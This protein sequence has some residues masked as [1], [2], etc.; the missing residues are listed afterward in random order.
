[1]RRLLEGN[2]ALVTGSNRG[3]GKAIVEA[4]ARHG[5]N[6]WACARKPDESFSAWTQSLA[7]EANV[8]IETAYFDLSD[9]TQIREGIKPVLAAKPPVDILVNNAGTIHTGLFQMTSVE[10]MKEVFETNFFSQ[11]VLTQYLLKGM[12]RQKKG[13]IVHVSSSAAI[14][15]NEGRSAYAASKA[16]LLAT[17][18]VM[19]KELSAFN[20][21]VNA[22]APGLTETDMMIQS[23][24]EN[25]LRETLQHTC[26]KRVG[27][28]EEIANAAVFL[29][30]E[31]SSFVTGQVIRV[32]GGM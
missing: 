18:K 24:P 25:A 16:A 23:T 32:D 22:I 15:G 9:H 21:R 1:M 31:M 4:F 29:C 17:T 8:R 14:D 12:T 5:A 2:T 27:R 11:M 10:K 13:S 30:S 7:K 3:I 26:L 20:I 28:P 19:A 6:I